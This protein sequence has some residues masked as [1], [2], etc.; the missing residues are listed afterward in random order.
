MNYRLALTAVLTLFSINRA[1]A[2]MYAKPDSADIFVYTDGNIGIGSP[3]RFD[4]S[5][6]VLFLQHHTLSIGYNSYWR[7]AP[8]IPPDMHPDNFLNFTPFQY[9]QEFLTGTALT[10]GYVLYPRKRPDLMRYIIRAGV[11][12][13]NYSNVANFRP[14]SGWFTSNY[15][16]DRIDHPTTAFILE[17]CFEYTPSRAFGLTA[18]AYACF[19][20]GLSGAGIKWGMLLGKVGNHRH[21]YR[22]SR[23]HVRQ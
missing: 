15:A 10:Y 8:N 12:L 4:A 5:L 23:R 3:F 16:Y 17:P 19:N 22:H 20:K 21:P 9:P 18:G 13:G 7:R 14:T 11:L 6:N 1:P 2:Q